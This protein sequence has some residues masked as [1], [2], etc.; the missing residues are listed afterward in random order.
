MTAREMAP[1]ALWLAACFIGSYVAMS[2]DFRP[3]RLG[4][5]RAS[6]PPASAMARSSTTDTI[7]MFLHP[8]CPCTRASVAQLLATVNAHPG[9]TLLVSLFAPPASADERAW[10]QGDD[11]RAIRA[12]VPDAALIPDRGGVEARRFGA[13]TSGTTLV[14]DRAGRE[15]FRGGITDRR[16]GRGDNPGLQRLAKTLREHADVAPGEPSPVF[17]CPIVAAETGK[18]RGA[19]APAIGRAR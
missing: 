1:C 6:W 17:G 7:V 14:Y 3:G 5:R 13:Q 8:R 12:A 10:L 4:A 19:D 18:P 11:A 9:A 15:I 16:G 2:M